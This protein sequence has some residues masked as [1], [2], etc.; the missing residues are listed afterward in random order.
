D[1]ADGIATGV[2]GVRLG[3]PAQF[4]FEG[5]DPE[6][7]ERVREA[8]RQLE[9]LGATPEPVDLPRARDVS[10]AQNLIT[11][12]EAFSEHAGRM[13]QAAEAYG[14]RTRRRIAS[15]AFYT[16]ADYDAA[17]H[18]RTAWRREVEAALR[19][20]DALITP[21]VPFPAF[22]VEAQLAASGPPDTGWLTRHF[23]FSGHPAVTL[24]C[25]RTGAGLP[26]GL[27]LAGRPFGEATLLRI[28]HA[29]EQ[30]TTWHTWRPEIREVA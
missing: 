12:V 28:A 27:Q 4:F 17:V 8:L 2:R 1:Y 25:G 13:R 18:L 15:G 6:V 3:V 21:T 16:T 14:L 29:Y 26:V 9:S 7:E 30:A 24:P 19:R 11:M 22:T 10:P 20:V 5:L 23:N